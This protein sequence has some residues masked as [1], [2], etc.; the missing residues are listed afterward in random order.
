MAT[1]LRVS[2]SF[3]NKPLTAF[4]LFGASTAMA[5]C[6][7]T[8]AAL[9]HVPTNVVMEAIRGYKHGSQPLAATA[10]KNAGAASP[11]S[12]ELYDTDGPYQAHL[13]VIFSQ[14][15]FAQ[16]EKEAREVRTNKTRL[17]GGVWKLSAFYEGVPSH[18]RMTAPPILTGNLT[19]RPSG[20]GLRL[21]PI[22]L[23][24]TSL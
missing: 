12:D 10:Q 8:Q 9:P 20:N 14:S 13:G 5:S 23:R 24:R 18:P 11:G 16:L 17:K 22:P 1:K 7:R 15:D 2:A 3:A 21:I 19:L 6:G 4:V